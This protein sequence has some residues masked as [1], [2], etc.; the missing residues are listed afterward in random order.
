M[1]K[2]LLNLTVTLTSALTLVAIAAPRA[3]ADLNSQTL[4]DIKSSLGLVPQFMQQVPPEALSGAWS[5]FKA[6]QLSSTTSLSG[7]VKELIGLGVAAQ[8]PCQYCIYFHTEAAKMNGAS[9]REVRE[10]V[11]LAATARHWISFLGGSQ[12]SFD[13]FKL[14]VDKTLKNSAEKMKLPRQQAQGN[15][16]LVELTS[17]AQALND[18][19]NT[20]GF[21]PGFI[22]QFSEAALPG[23]WSEM[24]NFYLNPNTALDMKTKD[25][26]GLA[27]AAQVPSQFGVYFHTESAKLNGATDQEIKEALAISSIT[28]YWSTILNGLQVNQVVFETEV[29]QIM[30]FLKAKPAIAP[31]P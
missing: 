26:I 21:I 5:E 8:I 25:L 20:L 19:G 4:S 28:R 13:E 24:K 22:K 15:T 14:D 17:T 16:E 29:Q 31:V 27:V 10:A 6:I 12:T 11:T 23:A 7:K 18:I 30:S 3:H 1:L 2:N 9:E